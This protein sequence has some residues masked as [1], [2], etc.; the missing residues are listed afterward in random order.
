MKPVAPIEKYWSAPE[1]WRG[2]TAVVVGGGPSLTQ[3]QCERAHRAGLKVLAVNDAIRPDRAPFADAHYFCDERW[4]RWHR[5]KRWYQDFR[6]LRVTLENP[7]VVA[8]DPTIKSMQNLGRDG[9]CPARHGLHTG[10]NGGYQAIGLAVHFGVARI[11]LIGFDLKPAA[12]GRSHWHGGHPVPVNPTAY[13]LLML[14]MFPSLIGPLAALGV[15]L[16]NC[17]PDSA[18]KCFPRMTLEEAIAAPPAR[19]AA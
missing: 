11:L 19:A 15:E 9:L 17:T 13:E 5:E 2:A 6:G 12:D 18:L 16:I 8:A 14:P 3:A 1:I 4:W 10:R 7:V